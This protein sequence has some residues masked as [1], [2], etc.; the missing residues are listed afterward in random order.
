MATIAAVLRGVA[1]CAILFERLLV[2][3]LNNWMR[4]QVARL[5][6]S[7]SSQRQRKN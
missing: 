6:P 3:L 4:H 5:D 7:A 1:R 2:K